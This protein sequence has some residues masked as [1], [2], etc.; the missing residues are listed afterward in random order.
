MRQLLVI[1]DF[2]DCQKL[3]KKR[4]IIDA[5]NSYKIKPEILS[6]CS[7]NKTVSVPNVLGH[8]TQFIIDFFPLAH[9]VLGWQGGH[10]VINQRCQNSAKLG[11]QWLEMVGDS[12][13]HR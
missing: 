10:F 7:L 4:T 13:G 12:L 5:K 3:S 6:L 1:S 2:L 9:S 11:C 8:L